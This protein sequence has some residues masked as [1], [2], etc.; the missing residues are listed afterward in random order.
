MTPVNRCLRCGHEG[1]DVSAILVDL[2]AEAKA[3]GGRISDVEVVQEIHHRH[4]TERHKAVVPERYG[5]EWRC[6]D[7]AA[8]SLRHAER[9]VEEEAVPWA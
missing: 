2:E 3:D 4:V 6:R 5:T 1:T 7:R 8:C 9:R